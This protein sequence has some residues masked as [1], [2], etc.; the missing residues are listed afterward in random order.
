LIREQSYDREFV[1]RWVNWEEYLRALHPGEP[2]TFERF[3]DEL[4]RLYAEYTPERA[5]RETGVPAA[6]IVEVAHAV[7]SAGSAFSAHN[8][9]A[10]A[11]GNL[12]GW[13]TA[14]CLFFLNVLTGS[15]GTKGGTIPASWTKFVPAPHA[16]PPHPKTWNDLTWPKEYPLAFFEMSFLL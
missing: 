3:G 15:V 1:R 4:A 7:A 16:R 9:R 6:T 5:E 11:A 14:R 12:G 10:A 13:M 2:V 8:W